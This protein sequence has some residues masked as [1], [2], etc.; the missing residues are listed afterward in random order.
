MALNCSLPLS[1]STSIIRMMQAIKWSHFLS[2]VQKTKNRWKFYHLLRLRLN[3]NLE[4]RMIMRSLIEFQVS[5]SA[6][7][8]YWKEYHPY[9]MTDRAFV[10]VLRLCINE[11][12]SVAIKICTLTRLMIL[13][14]FFHITAG[15]YSY[16]RMP[17]LYSNIQIKC[18][19]IKSSSYRSSMGR[20]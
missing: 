15:A 5:K 20:Q 1:G 19:F 6:R 9:N 13:K 17:L 11:M 8:R 14:S 10:A 18:M 7:K 12:N 4:T 3:F 16:I 2:M